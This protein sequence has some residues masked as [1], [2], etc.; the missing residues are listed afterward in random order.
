MEGASEELSSQLLR[1][2]SS[3]RLRS[4]QYAELTAAYLQLVERA[5]D[6]VVLDA[7]QS[8]EMAEKLAE[9]AQEMDDEL[10][11][12]DEVEALVKRT[13]KRLKALE[14]RVQRALPPR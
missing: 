13:L 12:I 3:V 14:K 5:V 4:A 10:A 1:L 8:C 9:A 2:V 6:A 7:E 11:R